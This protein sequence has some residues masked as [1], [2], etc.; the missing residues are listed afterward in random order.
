MGELDLGV[1]AWTAVVHERSVVVATHA[2]GFMVND[3]NGCFMD[4]HETRGIRVQGL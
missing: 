1:Q 2:F 3:D 4:L